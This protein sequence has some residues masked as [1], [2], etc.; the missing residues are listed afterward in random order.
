MNKIN[1]ENYAKIAAEDQ[2]LLSRLY[3]CIDAKS[4][5]ETVKQAIAAS[6]YELAGLQND[7]TS[8]SDQDLESVMGGANPFIPLSQG[9]INPYSWFVSF[10]RMLMGLSNGTEDSEQQTEAQSF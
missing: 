2:S 6:G 4:A 8:L 7:L 5:I 3:G 1:I 9:E 10:L